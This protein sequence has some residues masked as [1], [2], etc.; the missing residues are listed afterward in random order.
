MSHELF[1]HGFVDSNYNN[2]INISSDEKGNVIYVGSV[3]MIY[4]NNKNYYNFS[5]WLNSN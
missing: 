2:T 5:G 1:G 3:M 4:E